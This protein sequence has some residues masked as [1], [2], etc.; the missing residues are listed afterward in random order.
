MKQSCVGN[1]HPNKQILFLRFLIKLYLRQSNKSFTWLVDEITEEITTALKYIC[2]EENNTA[3]K[4]NFTHLILLFLTCGE[5]NFHD[6]KPEYAYY[7]K[8]QKKINI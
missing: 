3:I 6:L 8:F 5:L 4:M 7:G 1:G 2:F